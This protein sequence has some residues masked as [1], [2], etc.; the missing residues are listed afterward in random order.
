MY[1]FGSNNGGLS[2]AP[3]KKVVAVKLLNNYSNNKP[4]DPHSFKEEIKIKYNTIKAVAK[5]FPNRIAAIT[6]L[7]EENQYH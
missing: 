1:F 6:V 3:Y 5:K 2:Y 4:H 7:L